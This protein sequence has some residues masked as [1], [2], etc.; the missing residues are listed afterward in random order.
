MDQVDA[1]AQPAVSS[2]LPDPQLD[3]EQL[4]SIVMSTSVAIPAFQ[5]VTP[6]N[7][8][9]WVVVTC[10]IFLP[11]T[12]LAVVVRLVTRLQVARVIDLTDVLIVVSTVRYDTSIGSSIG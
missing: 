7:H 11:L 8:G 10:Y 6:N 1:Q 12:V 4:L 5:Q 3:H 2:P 9:P